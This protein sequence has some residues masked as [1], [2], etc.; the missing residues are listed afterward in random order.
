VKGRRCDVNRDGFF[1][2]KVVS[3]PFHFFTTFGNG[4]AA[5]WGGNSKEM[6]FRS[7]LL[8]KWKG[9]RYRYASNR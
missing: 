9:S 8:L 3:R 6:G 2:P 4:K 5:K 1:E 7:S